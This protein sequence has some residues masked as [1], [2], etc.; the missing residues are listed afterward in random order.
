MKLD[1]SVATSDRNCVPVKNLYKKQLK[2][3]IRFVGDHIL[4]ELYHHS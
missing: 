2:E 1:I 4:R 3:K